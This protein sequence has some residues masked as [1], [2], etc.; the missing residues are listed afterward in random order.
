MV[1]APTGARRHPGGRPPDRRAAAPDL[2]SVSDAGARC[3]SRG[4]PT[5]RTSWAT[6]ARPAPQALLAPGRGRRRSTGGPGGSRAPGPTWSSSPRSAGIADP[7]DAA[8]VEAYWVGSDLLDAVDR[9]GAAWRTSSD[10]FARP[11]RR[12]LARGRPTG[13]SPH[14]SFQVFEVYPWAGAARARTG[15]P[16][17]GVGARPLPDPHRRGDR[18]RR[19]AGDRVVPPAGAGTA[20]RLVPARPGRRAGPVVGRR[21]VAARRRRSSATGSRCTGTGCAT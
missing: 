6:A 11:V 20:R 13:R 5:R 19:R 2:L 15:H 7:L 4:T 12:H 18:G 21:P 1:V 8:V 17:G 16:A 14:H 3:C 9:R 10:R